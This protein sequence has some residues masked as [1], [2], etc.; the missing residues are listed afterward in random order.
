VETI[1][2]HCIG[3]DTLRLPAGELKGTYTLFTDVNENSIESVTK[4]SESQIVSR[5]MTHHLARGILYAKLGLKK[6]SSYRQDVQGPIVTNPSTQGDIDL[7]IWETVNPHQAIAMQCKRVKVMAIDVNNDRVN[8]LQEIEF[9]VEQTNNMFDLFKFSR[10]Y[11]VLLIAVDGRARN[12]YNM[13][14]RGAT[15]T[16]FKQCYDLEVLGRLKKEI[17]IIIV[18]LIQPSSSSFEKTGMIC[19][20]FG[21]EAKRDSQ[22]IR[23]TNCISSFQP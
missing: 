20:G 14:S 21:R 12:E 15:D 4:K 8:K 22:G 19:I 17:G 16:T 13:L 2:F 7:I 23:I 5:L 18:E 1:D 6:E 9:A 3:Y 11:M 10:T